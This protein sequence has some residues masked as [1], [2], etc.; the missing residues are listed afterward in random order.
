MD[1][2]LIAVFWSC[3]LV[4]AYAYVGYPMAIW[5]LAR[6]RPGGSIARCS[7]PASVSFVIAARDEGERIR[8]RIVELQHQ[9][10]HAA[11]A[12]EVIVVLDGSRDVGLAGSPLGT[13]YPVK[14]LPLAQNV[15]KSGAISKGVDIATGEIVAFAD[16]RQRWAE[17]ALARLLDR[18]ED[19]R[20][21]AVSGDL[22]LESGGANEGVSL[23]WRYEKWIRIQEGTFDSV[24]GVTGAIAAVRRSLFHAIPAGT[25]LDDVYWP[26]RVVM[27]GY[28]VVHESTAKAFDRLPEEVT[29]EFRR[30]V[31]TLAGNFQ[32]VTRLP[33]A[34]LPWKN[35]VW[36]QFVS[37]KLLRLAVPWAFLGAFVASAAIP[38]PLY[39]SLFWL[40]LVAYSSLMACWLWPS[41]KRGRIAAAAVS[42][43]MLNFAAWVA[44]W[45]WISGRTLKSWRATQYI[46]SQDSPAKVVSNA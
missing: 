40:Q 1:F 42:F 44:F 31:R 24:V 13:K 32:L 35:R 29:D 7:R 15:G 22:M 17:D 46:D 26:L 2:P 12:G 4:V 3:V 25:V 41:A 9:L 33:A 34:L 20:V 36:W 30:K 6:L 27:Q 8:G 38:T 11:V 10:E 14:I 43:A 23:Y 37:R 16:V 39:Q 45:V 21:G 5:L 28:R 19:S 18:F